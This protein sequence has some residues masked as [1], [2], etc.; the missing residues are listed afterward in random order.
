MSAP[1]RVSSPDEFGPPEPPSEDLGLLAL[2]D[3]AGDVQAVNSDV[4]ECT[5]VLS[6][7]L[8][9]RPSARNCWN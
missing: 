9:A 3:L 2:D 5:R 4:E 8:Q 6:Q 7:L 1:K